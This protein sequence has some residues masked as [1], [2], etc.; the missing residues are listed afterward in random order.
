[1][2][3]FKIGDIVCMNPK[4]YPHLDT[5][6]GIITAQTAEWDSTIYIIDWEDGDKGNTRLDRSGDYLILV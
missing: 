4:Y 6:R 5:V 1:M 2:K 3:T